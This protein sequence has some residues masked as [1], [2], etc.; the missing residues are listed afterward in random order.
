MQGWGTQQT[1][2]T[3]KKRASGDKRW[4]DP[5]I[6]SVWKVKRKGHNGNGWQT[7]RANSV[8]RLHHSEAITSV[9]LPTKIC[10]A[11]WNLAMMLHVAVKLVLAVTYLW[12]LDQV[13]NINRAADT[14]ARCCHVLMDVRHFLTH[15]HSQS[16]K[17]TVISKTIL[18]VRSNANSLNSLALVF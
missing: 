14:H 13:L 8:T 12:A 15:S 6:R 9:L 16:K 4:I 17:H 3:V 11:Q 5:K 10:E 1:T 2:K 18:H 7:Y